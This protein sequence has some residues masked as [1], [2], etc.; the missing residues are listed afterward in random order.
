M[1][2]QK[3][4]VFSGLLLIILLACLSIFEGRAVSFFPSP[5]IEHARVFSYQNA[6]GFTGTVFVM[7]IN[8]PS[9]EDVAS[10]TAT[11][12][13]GPF[14]LSP[15]L[16][17]R[18]DGL[19]Y[20]YTH[21]SIVDNGTYTFSV[22]DTYGRTASVHRDFTYNS[23]IPQVDTASMSPADQTYTGTTTPTL[24]FDPVAGDTVYYTVYVQDYDGN[25][26]WYMSDCTASTSVSIPERRSQ[27][28]TA[29]WWFVRVWDSDTNPQNCRE[30]ERLS[31]YTGTKGTP[32]INMHGVLSL[33]LGDNILNY[34]F[35]RA[36]NVAPWDINHLKVTRPDDNIH[37]LDGRH[38]SFAFPA[39]NEKAFFMDPPTISMPDGIYSFEVEDDQARTDFVTR[40]YTHDPVPEFE[41]DSRVPADNAHIN[42]NRPTF[43]WSRVTGDPG[44]GTYL[45]S[46][47]F[48]DYHGRIRFY[49]SP[50]STATSFTI[51]DNV[52]VP[53][54]VFKWRVNVI[55]NTGNNF[56]SSD[57]RTVTFSPR[58]YSAPG[59]VTG[60]FDGNG[61]DDLAGLNAS[62]NIYYTTDLSSWTQI[63]GTLKSLTVGDFNND[64]KDDLAGLNGS[65]SIFYTTNLNTWT[66]IPGALES[67][68]AGDFNGDG[69]SD[70]A[71][72]NVMGGI[73]YTTDLSTWI[74]VPGNI[75][76]LDS[77]DFDND[78]M[79]DLAGL[80]SAGLIYYTT[81]LNTWTQVPGSLEDLVVGDFNH[82]GLD[83][84]AGLNAQ[85][86][87][88]Y[89][90]EHTWHQ[91]PG[92]MAQLL[93]ADLNGDGAG[94]LAGLNSLGYIYYTTDLNTWTQ[95]PGQ[96]ANMV[97]GNL[98]GA[99]GEDLAGLNGSG[100]I[101]YT[102][103]LSTWTQ[104]PGNLAPY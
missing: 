57:Y 82:D 86:H 2:I 76:K 45:Y 50:R 9:P 68:A 70:L 90:T 24:S 55:D 34:P 104:V 30:S 77:G 6:G 33:P 53:P 46:I 92:T 49:D 14:D 100:E 11:G 35:A 40:S 47:R 69:N 51:P 60:D 37:E 27:P 3:K 84:I 95:I 56:R 10:I 32:E 89:C 91:V 38:Y 65:G 97:S 44:D 75:E 48:T 98:D 78:G 21:D 4:L 85:G 31:F 52:D 29:F 12:P 94:D 73:Y 16:T 15:G 71:G 61:S 102:A 103:D 67:L 101:F 72:L 96:L 63:P 74:Q 19:Y 5:V 25:A 8:G 93:S 23:T 87:V 17:S 13:S 80:N 28:N 7:N 58:Q 36:V 43:S 83:D 42:T 66:Q 41:S 26:F 20:N 54:Y 99:N 88:Y 64:G 59:F 18:R 22:T 1:R 79:D 62:G 39:Y 81:D